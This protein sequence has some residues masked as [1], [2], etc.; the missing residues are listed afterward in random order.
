ME[1]MCGCVTVSDAEAASGTCAQDGSQGPNRLL[2]FYH[3]KMREGLICPSTGSSRRS[4]SVT[5][6]HRVLGPIFGRGR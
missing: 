5:V 2:C 4:K 3:N 1:R 6:V